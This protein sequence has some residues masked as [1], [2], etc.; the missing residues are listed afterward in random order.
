MARVDARRLRLPT[1][2]S[3]GLAEEVRAAAPEVLLEVTFGFAAFDAEGRLLYLRIQDHLRKLGLAR[4]AQLRLW[5]D[6]GRIVWRCPEEEVL[7]RLDETVDLDEFGHLLRS[8]ENELRERARSRRAEE[9][10]KHD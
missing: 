9:E 1:A 10:T 5:N 4:R 2:R 3:L 7:A 6:R 8:V